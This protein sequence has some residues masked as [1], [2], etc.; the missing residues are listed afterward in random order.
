MRDLLNDI[1]NMESVKGVMIL[2]TDGDVLFNEMSSGITDPKGK[3]WAFFVDAMKDTSE[4]ELVFSGARIYVRKS[5][6]S[7]VVILTDLSVPMPMLRLNCDIMLPALK[8]AKGSKGIK[9]FFKR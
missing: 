9:G 7:Y 4:A 2:S 8:A 1:L 3:E 6:T 5:G